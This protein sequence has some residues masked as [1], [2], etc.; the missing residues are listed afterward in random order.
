MPASFDYALGVGL[1][2]GAVRLFKLSPDML[3]RV[4]MA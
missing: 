1:A 4:W 3:F 2:L